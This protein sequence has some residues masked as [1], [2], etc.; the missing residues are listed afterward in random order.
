[1][2]LRE[3]VEYRVSDVEDGSRLRRLMG[4]FIREWEH[5]AKKV[6]DKFGYVQ[7]DMKGGSSRWN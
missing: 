1:M 5:Q 3:E 6:M 2:L 7:H 4:L